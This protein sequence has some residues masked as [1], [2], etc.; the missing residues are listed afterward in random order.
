MSKRYKIGI[1]GASTTAGNTD[2]EKYGWVNRLRDEFIETIDSFDWFNLS[3]SGST[4]NNLVERFEI[5]LRHRRSNIVIISIGSNDSAQNIADDTNWVPIE[6][7][8]EN[9]M[10]IARQAKKFADHIIFVG[11]QKM[12][13][14]NLDPCP[15]N[16]EIR[17]TNNE[18]KR[19]EDVMNKVAEQIGGRFIS[20]FDVVNLRDLSDG[21][22]PNAAGHQKI[23]EAVAPVLRDIIKDDE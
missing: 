4:S 15:W 23:A 11:F 5:E 16:T 9:L 3:I 18:L 21:V 2:Y 20:L 7:F 1:W 6:K 8:H 10:I 13:E 17:Y 12:D 22:H 19:Y 14:K